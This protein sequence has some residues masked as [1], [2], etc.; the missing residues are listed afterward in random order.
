MTQESRDFAALQPCSQCESYLAEFERPFED[1]RAMRSMAYFIGHRI[2]A[3]GYKHSSAHHTARA[4][5]LKAQREVNPRLNE[6]GLIEG[7]Y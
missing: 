7:A 4:Q 6:F 1:Q 5:I 3:H 2:R